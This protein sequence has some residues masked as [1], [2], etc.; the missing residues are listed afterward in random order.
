MQHLSN[1]EFEALKTLSKNCNL[2]IQKANKGNS[3]VIV[4]EDVYLRH[5]ESILSDLNKFE[6]LESREQFWI[7][8][9][10]IKKY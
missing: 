10:T 9:L 6:K 7:F 3:V 5:M 2:V 4:Q 8:Q 1:E